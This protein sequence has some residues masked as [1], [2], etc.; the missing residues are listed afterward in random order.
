MCQD[1][2]HDTNSFRVQLLRAAKE[3]QGGRQGCSVLMKGGT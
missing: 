3:A 1:S 2:P